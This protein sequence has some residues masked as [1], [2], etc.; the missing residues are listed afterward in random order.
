LT[1]VKLS[2][3]LTTIGDSAFYRCRKLADIVIPASVQSL[4]AYAFAECTSLPSIIIPEGVASISKYAFQ[5]CSNL[6]SIEIPASMTSIGY[7]AFASCSSLIDVY[8]TGDQTA[9][10][11]ISI[12]VNNTNLTRATIHYNYISGECGTDLTWTLDADGLLTIRGS[13]EMNDYTSSPWANDTV[14]KVVMKG[15]ITRIGNYA[16]SECHNLTSVTI[17]S[18]VTSIGDYAF[19]QCSFL[20]GVILPDGLTSMGEY[21][22]A[23]CGFT[24]VAIPSGI[25]S[26]SKSTFRSCTRLT[27]V[28]IPVSVTRIYEAAFYDCSALAN[29]FYEGT[30]YAW[31]TKIGFGPYN[32]NL[33]NAKIHYTYTKTSA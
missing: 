25:T 5:A 11:K 20:S 9:W 26:I 2:D 14:K 33:L 1:S 19:Y 13:G 32:T 27:S 12:H 16:F 24:S 6:T 23:E 15:G 8:Y 4:G 18:S 29:V 7:S 28:S 22:F 17:P 30:F 31:K 21:A 10:K 3:G